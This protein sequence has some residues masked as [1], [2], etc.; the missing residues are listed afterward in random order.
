LGTSKEFSPP[1]EGSWRAPMKELEPFLLGGILSSNLA[2][3]ALSDYVNA[4]GGP[5]SFSINGG[6]HGT[7]NAG[8]RVA[9]RIGGFLSTY[10]SESLYAAL[11]SIGLQDLIGKSAEEIIYGLVDRIG[12]SA[13][14]IDDIDANNALASLWNELLAGAETYEDVDRILGETLNEQSLSELILKF[15]G[16][17]L[18]E[19][20]CRV[21]YQLVSSKIGNENTEEYFEQIKVYIKEELAYQLSNDDATSVDW[22][23]EEGA[24]ICQN[25]LRQTLEVFCGGEA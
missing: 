11:R 5:V 20:F 13:T 9:Q 7:S 19:Q 25:I 16:F 2:K 22:K 17:Y 24:Q 1:T 4:N 23:S 14:F 21:H 15:F 6:R 10:T 3:K 18:Y 8:K 12:G